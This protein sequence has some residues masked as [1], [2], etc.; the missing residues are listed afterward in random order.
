MKIASLGGIM[1]G[2]TIFD[3]VMQFVRG[4]MGIGWA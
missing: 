1:F 3:V 2:R 4:L